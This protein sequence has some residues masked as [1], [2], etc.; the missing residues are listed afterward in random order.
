VVH[1]ALLQQLRVG[2]NI[3]RIVDGVL[4]DLF[5]YVGMAPCPF[6]IISCRSKARYS[7]AG[8]VTL[9]GAYDGAHVGSRDLLQWEV[10]LQQQRQR[11]LILYI[12]QGRGLAVL[13]CAQDI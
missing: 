1:F 4:F 12:A 10:G 8:T 9:G 11:T 7:S 6:G 5:V 2:R 3:P 13:H